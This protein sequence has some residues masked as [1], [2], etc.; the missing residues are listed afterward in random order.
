[1]AEKKYPDMYPGWKTVGRL[2]KGGFGAVYEIE[3]EHFGK[4]EK[5]A[6]KHISIPTDDGDIE[7]LRSDGYD[8]ASITGHFEDHLG[9][10]VREYFLMAE[11]KGH[12]NVVDCDDVLYIQ[13]DDGFGWDI[14]I[15]M[16]LL[17]PVMKCVDRLT[18]EEE[19]I[20]LGVDICNAL[21]LCGRKEIIHRDI[22]PQ[23][24][25]ISDTGD[26]KLGDFG[27]AR[28]MEQ[29]THVTRGI[30]TPSYMAPEVFNN[31]E[32]DSRVD[33]YSLGMVLYWLLNERRTP[34]LPLTKKIPTAE[35]AG[36][37]WSRRFSGEAIPAPK[38]GSKALKA[39][40]L[41]ACAFK[42][43]DRYQSAQEMRN[44]L[45][46]LT[47]PVQQA[48]PV[49]IVDE[50]TVYGKTMNRGEEKKEVPNPDLTVY[51]DVGKERDE[52]CARQE[53]AERVAK[54]QEKQETIR[55]A[56]EDLAKLRQKQQEQERIRKAR[57]ELEEL[58]KQQREQEALRKEKEEQERLEKEREEQKRRQEEER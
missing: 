32:Y 45:V 22:K 56:Q 10:I 51:G 54:E 19:I 31:Q 14:Y 8:D 53:A 12:T 36:N 39:I 15:K 55:K 49:E 1:M 35:E 42:P 50:K 2:G 21:I 38:N 11:M 40:V 5:A 28:S 27:I 30:G 16:E 18:S 13:H 7:S 24:I 58:R 33:T 57:E 34:F 9:K 26:Y 29:A 17:T 41:K 48:A 37:A 44:A 6:L 46:T 52:E 47:A 3:R 4:C 23:N 43:E 20:Q 25:F